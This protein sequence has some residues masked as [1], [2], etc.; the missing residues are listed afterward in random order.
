VKGLKKS[1]FNNGIIFEQEG[2]KRDNYFMLQSFI[3]HALHEMIEA[4]ETTTDENEYR[5]NCDALLVKLRKYENEYALNIVYQFSAGVF[6]DEA[7]DIIPGIFFRTQLIYEAS[8]LPLP[9]FYNVERGE[10]KK[11]AFIPHSP[12]STR[13]YAIIDILGS[14]QKSNMY[15]QKLPS[16]IKEKYKSHDFVLMTL[17]PGLK[18]PSY[19]LH[20]VIGTEVLPFYYL[21]PFNQLERV[22]DVCKNTAQFVIL[23]NKLQTKF[24]ESYGIYG[25]VV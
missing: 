25:T 15:Y 21:L 17:V 4:N 8:H 11:D 9:L 22:V 18:P 1:F 5:K 2:H 13:A 6:A 16:K 10:I 19:V 3:K 12:H 14:F 20:D 24:Y 7:E 23:C